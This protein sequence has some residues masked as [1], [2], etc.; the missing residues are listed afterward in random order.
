MGLREDYSLKATI[1]NMFKELEKIIHEG[2]YNDNVSQILTIH[3]ET[4]LLKNKSG[5]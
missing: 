5:F 1:I 3:K 2:R 4:L